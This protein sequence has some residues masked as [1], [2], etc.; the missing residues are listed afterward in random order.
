V[1]PAKARVLDA[2]SG[3]G[4]YA[5]RMANMRR[6]WQ[7]KAIDVKG[8]QVDA[9]NRFMEQTGRGGQVYFETADLCS[10]CEPECY[11]LVLSVDVME[12]I[13]D[14]VAVFRNIFMSLRS[15]GMLLISTPSDRG[16]S[17][18]DSHHGSFIDEHVRDGYSADELHSKL[19]AT[20]FSNIC[21]RYSYG[22]TGHLSWLLS[23]KYPMLL[24][25]ISK[26]FFIFLPFYYLFTFPISLLL[27]WR[28]TAIYHTSGTGLIATAVKM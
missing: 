21:I 9:C 22:R 13:E 12:H 20:G 2:G 5:W 24:V 27:N 17:D 28:D 19:T 16:G 23:I 3:F 4:Q 25:G 1:L 26:M 6:G 7:I 11:H 14:D 10:F 15:G 8:E 18:A